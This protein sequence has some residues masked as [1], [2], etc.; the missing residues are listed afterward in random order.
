MSL[1]RLKVTRYC[2]RAYECLETA[3]KAQTPGGS[4][5]QLQLAEWYLFLAQAELK[6]A[7]EIT[8]NGRRAHGY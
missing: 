6:H 7:S 1:L 5:I 2:D 8:E 4:G 3:A